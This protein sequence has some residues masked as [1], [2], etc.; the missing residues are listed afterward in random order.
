M[1]DPPDEPDSFPNLRA[2]ALYRE[3]LDLG[4]RLREH[5]SPSLSERYQELLAAYR[6]EVAESEYDP[7]ALP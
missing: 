4:D 6:A 7:D 3:L 2:E 1:V 5:G